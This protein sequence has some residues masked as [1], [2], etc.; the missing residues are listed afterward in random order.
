MYTGFKKHYKKLFKKP[1]QEIEF[2]SEPNISPPEKVEH[3]LHVSFNPVTK[4]LEGLPEVWKDLVKCTV[5]TEEMKANPNAVIN[6]VI[7]WSDGPDEY[8]GPC[9]DY[10]PDEPSVPSSADETEPL[11]TK[12]EEM[13]I[14]DEEN[15]SD[16]EK[17][18]NETV[19][20]PA[21]THQPSVQVRKRRQ[22][23][24]D[25]VMKELVKV[26]SQENAT[27]LYQ[28]EQELGAGASGVVF[29]CKDKRFGHKVAV[30]DIDLAKQPKKSLILTEIK[31]MKSIQHE[32]LVNFLD[33]FLVEN[34]LWVIMELL[35][36]GPLTDVVLETVMT[37]RQIAAVTQKCLLAINYLHRNVS[38]FPILSLSYCVIQGIQKTC[39]F[40]CCCT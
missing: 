40:L 34:H 33:V 4:T 3:N 30:K 1:D 2:N 13:K 32:N 7:L 10:I 38:S 22:L 29:V 26:C 19:K 17:K 9:L 35:D 14:E 28:K 24:D 25:E 11:P 6:A 27:D 37:E 21:L 20:E 12:L 5:S 18:E 15:K 31:V 36:G 23:S 16:V 39:T 8:R